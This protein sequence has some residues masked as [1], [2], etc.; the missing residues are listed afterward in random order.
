MIVLPVI[1]RELRVQ[2]RQAFTYWLRVLGAGTL[3]LIGIYS[4]LTR[5][6]SLMRPTQSPGAELFGHLTTTLFFAIWIL[7]PLA[8]A[9]CISRER[10]EDTL[11]LL[12]LTPLKSMDIVT[13]KGLV[14][15]LRAFTFWFAILPVMTVPSL[16]GGVSWKEAAL[17]ALIDFSAICWALAAGVLASSL[18][19]SWLRSLLA[20]GIFGF[21]FSVVF[22]TMHSLSILAAGVGFPARFQQEMQDVEQMIVVGFLAA[23]DVTGRWSGMSS[24]PNLP[25]A[26]QTALVVRE[27]LAALFSVC[28]LFLILRLAAWN[29]RRNWRERQRSA[30]EI[31]IEQKFFTPVVAVRF[32]RRWMLRKLERNP[33]GWL[34]QRTWSGRVAVWGWLAVIISVY[35][36]AL[37]DNYFFRREDILQKLMAWLMLGN[38]A[39]SAVG[40]FRRERE[41][42]VLELL[43]VTP[44]SEAQIILGR[45][46]GLWGQF[47]PAW[48]LLL[49]VW[50]YFIDAFGGDFGSLESI[51]FFVVG[52]FTVPV[53]GLYYSLRRSN[54]VS[55]LLSTIV[56]GLL[57]PVVLMVAVAYVRWVFFGAL[58]GIGGGSAELS[59][60]VAL[61]SLCQ[62][63]VAVALGR[64]LYRD[65]V[66]RRFAFE[67]AMN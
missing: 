14:H 63:L 47:L 4:E 10:R 32:F 16:M 29:V 18:S 17:A 37:G 51:W 31:W 48:G 26:A 1:E 50:L 58:L 22:A 38:M 27:G 36:A 9:D 5:G 13:A 28:V 42:G 21:L 20:A 15:G 56:A 33:V 11:G 19:K 65:L 62:V 66:L 6:W 2:S 45:L 57:L 44:T 40:S 39:A 55:A 35:S 23:A 41:T 46:R 53:I 3:V 64:R 59:Q 7:V 49:G 24:F 67:R 34:Q 12:F 52:F 43:L 8:T 61:I 30:R 60:G 54:F 25:A